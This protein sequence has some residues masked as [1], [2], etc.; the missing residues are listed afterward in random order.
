MSFTGRDL[1]LALSEDVG[2][3][4]SM[5]WYAPPGEEYGSFFDVNAPA[6]GQYDWKSEERKYATVRNLRSHALW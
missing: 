1:G 2:D 5:R 3:A 4:A 6:A